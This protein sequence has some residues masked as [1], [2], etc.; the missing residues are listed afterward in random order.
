LASTGKKWLIGCGT[1]CAVSTLLVIVISVGTGIMMTRPFSKA[2]DVQ[3][4][5]TESYGKREEY[6]PACE[7]ITS[8]RLEAFLKVRATLMLE[9]KGFE[10]IQAKFQFMEDMDNSEEEPSKGEIVKG[11]GNVMGAVFSIGGKIG[12]VTLVRNEALL[13][14]EM[15]LGEYNWLFI[16]IYYSW[17]NHPPNTGFEG[18]GGELSGSERGYLLKMMEYHAVH[19]ENSGH[20]QLA[21]LWRDEAARMQ[22][23]GDDVPFKETSLPSK[24]IRVLEPYRHDL[25]SHYCAA[26]AEFELGSIQKEGYFGFRT[27]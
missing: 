23:T 17:L 8:D 25:E 4:Q 18:E 21:E 2:V 1:G 9:C 5:L 24:L 19:C 13:A 3:N 6:I 12:N 11:V 14:N 22:R 20:S 27:E 10:N 26:M 15:S 7:G 16:L